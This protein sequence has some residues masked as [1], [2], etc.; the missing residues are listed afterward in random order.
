MYSLSILTHSV[1]PMP[2]SF[3]LI[4]LLIL[5]TLYRSS[6]DNH[7]CFE[8]KAIVTTPHVDDILQPSPFS[9]FHLSSE[10]SL[11]IFPKP[12]S[13]WYDIL[14]STEHLS[15]TYSEPLSRHELFGAV[16]CEERFF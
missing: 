15:I 6:E 12:S 1:R 3:P 7:K 16:H 4:T 13:E 2:I 8:F 11:I 14:V 5:S 10:P 9:N